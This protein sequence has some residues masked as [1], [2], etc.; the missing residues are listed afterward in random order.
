MLVVSEM[1]IACSVP[2]TVDVALT[3][4]VS[5]ALA[6]S[7]P[8]VDASEDAEPASETDVPVDSVTAGEDVDVVRPDSVEEAVSVEFSETAPVTLG[9]STN[10][11]CS[12]PV[13]VTVALVC[14]DS[15]AT[16]G[17]LAVSVTVGEPVD[18]ILPDSEI[19]MSCS[20]VEGVAVLPTEPASGTPTSASVVVADAVPVTDPDSA[21]RAVSVPVALVAADT[22]PDSDTVTG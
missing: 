19:A 10:A 16:L 17:E 12:T 5:V 8:D 15:L 9:D 13:T 6:V 21:A 4:S 22:A 1:L 3:D 2:A 11:A 20:T 18:E 7:T 14:P